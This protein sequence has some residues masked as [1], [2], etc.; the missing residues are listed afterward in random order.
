LSGARK[1]WGIF[2]IV[3][4]LWSFLGG[5]SLMMSDEVDCGG[6]TMSSSDTCVTYDDGQTTE[7]SIDE[8]QRSNRVM[9][10]AALILSLGIVVWGVLILRKGVKQKKAA[11]AGP[12]QPP[13]GAYPQQPGQYPPPGHHPQQGQHPQQPGFPPQQAAP[14]QWQQPG[15]PDGRP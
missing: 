5:V 3:I 15:G 10:V 11:Q 9:G 6:D 7:R 13:P 2:A 14:A 4:G 12:Q 1:F 8:Q